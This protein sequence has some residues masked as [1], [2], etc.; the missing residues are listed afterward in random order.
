[1][2]NINSTAAVHIWFL[3]ACQHGEGVV[4]Y[5]YEGRYCHHKQLWQLCWC[6][7]PALAQQ[8]IHLLYSLPWHLLPPS[9]HPNHLLPRQNKPDKCSH[10]SAF[11]LL[12]CDIGFPAK[13][14]KRRVAQLSDLKL[15]CF[16]LVYPACK[17]IENSWV[18]VVPQRMW[19]CL[20]SE[21]LVVM[22]S[23]TKYVKK[24]TWRWY[25]SWPAAA[26]HSTSPSF[27]EAEFKEFTILCQASL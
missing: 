17:Q 3:V 10:N 14:I 25:S 8:P 7:H 12:M 1:M 19:L 26:T 18:H 11:F 24:T 13:S 2:I 9:P 23:V 20:R 6:W 16:I 21:E 5:D 4:G 22:N 15:H 27:P